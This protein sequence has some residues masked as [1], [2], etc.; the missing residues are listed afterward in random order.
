MQNACEQVHIQ[1]NADDS[2]IAVINRTYHQQEHLKAEIAMYDINGIKRF[3]QNISLNLKS[4]DV[5]EILPLSSVLSGYSD[6]NFLVLNLTDASGNTVSHNV[7]WLA[8]NHQYQSLQQIQPAKLD[9]KI[10]IKAAGK[11]ETRWTIQFTNTTG[12]MA[13]F[14]HPKFTEGKEEIFP[15]FW[16]SNYFTLA[17]GEKIILNASY[18]NAALSHKSVQ[19]KLSGWNRNDEWISNIQ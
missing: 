15:G 8:K 3:A 2:M 14:V 17:P 9:T 4:S 12:K 6:L 19:L 16:S 11:T 10:L 1:F 5:K 13:F 18:P 7:Y